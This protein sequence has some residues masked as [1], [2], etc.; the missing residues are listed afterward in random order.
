MDGEADNPS[1]ILLK[2]NNLHIEIQVDY[3]DSI[4]ASAG[5]SNPLLAKE[6]LQKSRLQRF[7][8]FSSFKS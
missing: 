1:S 8:L 3:E 4:G 2:N 7:K 5:I 6:A